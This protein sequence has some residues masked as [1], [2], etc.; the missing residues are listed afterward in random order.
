[1]GLDDFIR[2]AGNKTVFSTDELTEIY[3]KN[4][5]VVIIEMV[6]NGFFGKGNNVNHRSLCEK[7]LFGS[8]PYE[9]DYN[10]NDFIT[11][12]EMGEKNARDVIID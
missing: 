12:L 2:K 10:K 3:L 4:K 1:M 6:Y 9:I 7:G 5:N 8:H 11:I